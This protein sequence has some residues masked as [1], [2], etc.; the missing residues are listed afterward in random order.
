MKIRKTVTAVIA[1][2]FV[3]P[4]S[5]GLFAQDTAVQ[6][7]V[8]Y[9]KVIADYI[10]ATGGEMAHKAIESV[11]ASGKM[12]IPQVGIE[13]EMTMMH[14]GKKVF[15]KVTMAGIGEERMGSD[16]E[17]LWKVSEMTGP[18]IIEGEQREQMLREFNISPYLN[19]DKQYDSVECT[20]KE[21]FNGEECY[22]LKAVKGDADPEWHYFSVESHLLV[23]KKMTQITEMGNMEVVSKI[24][25]YKEVGGVKMSHS[26]TVELP[27]G[28][29]MVQTME[30]IEVNPEIKSDVFALPEEIVDL[31]KN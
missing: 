14:S 7:K 21:K 29:S 16:G 20:G 28:M 25:D 15:V 13:G 17:T 18:Q 27:Q 3:L 6:D 24:G 1:A 26:T 9:K 19:I 4:L 12:S 11:S 30:K 23:G 2:L 31:K 10:E 5:S 22:V 8:D